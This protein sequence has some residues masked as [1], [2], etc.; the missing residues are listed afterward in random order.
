MAAPLFLYPFILLVAPEDFVVSDC[1][2]AG[3]PSTRLVRQKEPSR[4]S[5]GPVLRQ[6]L[7]SLE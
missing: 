7:Y 1:A 5:G 3:R 4:Q 2:V 6:E